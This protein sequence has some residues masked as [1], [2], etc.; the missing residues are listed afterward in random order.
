M[1]DVRSLGLP[2][3]RWVPDWLAVAALFIVILPVLMVNGAYTGSMLVEHHKGYIAENRTEKTR[4]FMDLGFKAAYDFKLYKSITLQ[5]N[6]GVQN[7][8]NAYQNDFDKGSDRDSG[9][10]YG[11]S[12]PRSFYAGL[13][14]SY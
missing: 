5:I 7:I 11:P 12:L 1:M 9:Y 13:K 10:I 6:A 14:L 4:S 3:R 2:V 8:F